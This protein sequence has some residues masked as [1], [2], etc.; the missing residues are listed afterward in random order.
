MFL[1]VE[2]NTGDVS[3]WCWA[4][5]NIGEGVP[6]YEPGLFKVTGHKSY[7]QGGTWPRRFV[8]ALKPEC[9]AYRSK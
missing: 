4:N 2:G 7:D 9:G 5:L 8:I 3:W 1:K 6:E